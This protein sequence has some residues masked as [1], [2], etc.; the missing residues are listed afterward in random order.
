MSKLTHRGYFDGLLRKLKLKKSN[1]QQ[2]F[3]NP[4]ISD[5]KAEK[6]STRQKSL[7]TFRG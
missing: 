3:S 6:K 2:D 5:S 4:V 7:D 1:K